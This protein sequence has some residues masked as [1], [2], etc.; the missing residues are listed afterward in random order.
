M[1]AVYSCSAAFGPLPVVPLAHVR[2]QVLFSFSFF[3]LFFLD[4]GPQPLA[5]LRTCHYARTTLAPPL[6]TSLAHWPARTCA[7]LPCRPGLHPSPAGRRRRAP[8]SPGGAGGTA[9][10]TIPIYHVVPQFHST[11][12]APCD[13]LDFDSSAHA[14]WM[15]MCA[16][17]PMFGP[18]HVFRTASWSGSW[19]MPRPPS[20]PVWQLRHGVFIEIDRFSSK[21]TVSHAFSSATPPQARQHATW[22]P[23]FIGCLSWCSQPDGVPNSRLQAPSSD[24]SL[25]VMPVLSRGQMRAGSTH[26]RGR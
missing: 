18:I 25:W 1:A 26:A 12:H 9:T 10:S 19:T 8:G 14:C 16:C 22:H 13:I 5:P 23:R 24:S 6:H 4:F 20:T 3:F 7:H 11:P 15:P 17:D 2:C 21:L